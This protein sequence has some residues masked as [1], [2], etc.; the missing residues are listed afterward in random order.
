MGLEEMEIPGTDDG[1][2]AALHPE[3]ATEVIDVPLDRVHAH[4]EATS[5]LTVGGTRKQQVQH[6]TLALGQRFGKRTW[7]D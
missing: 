5:D 4:D 1:L 2:R 6:L 7:T 3:F